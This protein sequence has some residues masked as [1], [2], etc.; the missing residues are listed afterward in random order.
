MWRSKEDARKGGLGPWHKKARFAARELYAE[1]TFTSHQFTV[2]DGVK[3][4]TFEDWVE[5]AE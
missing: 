1:I 4:W 3:D 2:G 5:K